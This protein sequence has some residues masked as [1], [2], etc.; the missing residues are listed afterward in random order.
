MNLRFYLLLVDL[1]V[2]QSTEREQSNT[3]CSAWPDR[4]LE[5]IF[6][7]LFLRFVDFEGIKKAIGY[8]D[9]TWQVLYK[10]YCIA[11]G[12][13]AIFLVQQYSRR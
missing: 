12:C 5:I 8:F 4:N 3:Q 1:E 9:T 10:F 7:E 11:R 13:C 2:M 6:L